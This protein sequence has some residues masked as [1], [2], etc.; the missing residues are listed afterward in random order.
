VS[1]R[2]RNRELWVVRDI[3]EANAA[4]WAKLSTALEQRWAKEGQQGR[5]FV[6]QL[7]REGLL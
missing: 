1:K 6:K 4:M 5:T 2:Q 7:K 3:Q